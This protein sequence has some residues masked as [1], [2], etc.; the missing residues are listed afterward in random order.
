MNN[1]QELE[2]R[3]QK[4][5]DE[6][7]LK[8]RQK[9]LEQLIKDYKGKCFGSHTFER[10]ST[11]EHMGAT[12]YEDFFIKDSLIYVLE[13]TLSLSKNRAYDKNT[14]KSVNYTRNVHKRCLTDGKYHADYK[15]YTGYSFFRKEISYEKFMSLWES[16]EE[17]F[18][19]LKK[20]F[21]GKNPELKVE[22]ITQGD[23]GNE[24]K[25]EEWTKQNGVEFIDFKDFPKVHNILEYRTLPLFNR[26]RWLPKLYAKSIL[27]WEVNRIKKDLTSPFTTGRRYYALEE[28]IKIIEEF[29]KKEL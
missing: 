25:I 1:I 15:L 14:I 21:S 4:A 7:V 3:L 2:K 12:Y 13:W 8:A 19:I 29:I 22:N 10:A 9:E 17:A 20:T 5:K 26:R 24:S 11:C 23:Y 16:G 6:E 18:I 27:N 28:E